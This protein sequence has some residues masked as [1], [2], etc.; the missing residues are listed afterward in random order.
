[1]S[2]TTIERVEAWYLR[3]PLGTPIRLGDMVIAER[4]FVVLRVRTAGGLDGVA[5]SLTRGA[6]L[7][8]VLTETIGPRVLGRE[9]LDTR[10]RA[11]ELRVSVRSLGAVG[12]IGRAI[13][14]VDIA[15][16][17]IA[18][19]ASG[20]PIWRMLGGARHAAPVLL[21]A[22]YAAP[23]EPD[24]GYAERI[25]EVA[26]RG[27]R[28]VKLYPTADPDV[29]RRRLAAI[30]AATGPALRLVVDM[31][32]S[33]GGVLDAIRAVRSW[34]AYELTWVEDPYGA[35]EWAAI[36]TLADAVQ[37]PIAVGDEVSVRGTMERLIEER[38]VDVVRLDV[39]SIGGFA[40][41]DALRGQADRAGLLVSPH[42]YGEIHQ[43][44]IFGWPGHG[45]V[46]LFP[47]DSPTWGAGRFLAHQLDA[48]GDS[49]LLEA[50]SEPGLGLRL[51]HGAVERLAIRHTVTT[52]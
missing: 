4:D 24:E 28:Y 6:P 13:S 29:M 16:W 48:V 18:G 11:D 19:Q 23:D 39:T 46:E 47:P 14:L 45:P 22:P 49:G 36:K 2:D 40:A 12:L 34:E 43:H 9:A 51:D 30:R 44:C 20:M 38:A 37:T 5:Y 52:R 21:V 42:A 10:A 35:D 27:Y 17:D 50:P 26:G 25:A 31:A 3:V 15:L 8:L 7:D 32:W 1:M 41:Y 33:F